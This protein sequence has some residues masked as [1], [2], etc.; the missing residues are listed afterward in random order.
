MNF[1]L[2]ENY[3]KKAFQTTYNFLVTLPLKEISNADLL[4]EFMTYTNEMDKY[5]TT[6]NNLVQC[7]NL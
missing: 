7:S 2:I 1:I 3:I 6:I 4:S 5:H